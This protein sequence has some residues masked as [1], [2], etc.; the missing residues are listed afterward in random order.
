[1]SVAQRC[2]RRRGVVEVN[3]DR[4]IIDV[5]SRIDVRAAAI[6]RQRRREVRATASERDHRHHKKS[7]AKKRVG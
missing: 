5:C 3:D 4:P 6:G 7:R 2:F 1:L